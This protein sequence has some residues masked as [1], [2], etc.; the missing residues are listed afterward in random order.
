[1]HVTMVKKRLKDGSDC[2]KCNEA[3]E[4]L[5][6]RGLLERVDEVV[7]A[8]EGDPN[9]PGMVLGNR[10]GVESAPFFVVR[11][12]TGEHVYTSVL[13]LIQERFRERVS[14]AER[15]RSVDPD[16]IGGI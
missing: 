3:T 2:R 8:V 13:S 1:M 15:A 11:D 7:W 4:H 6:R 9:S 14:D 10:L 12:A 5:K 16:E